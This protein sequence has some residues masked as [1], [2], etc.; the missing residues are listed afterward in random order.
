MTKFKFILAALVFTAFVATWAFAGDLDDALAASQRGD[1]E[2]ALKLLKPLAEQGKVDGQALFLGHIDQ[3]DGQ[4]D[5]NAEFHQLSRQIQ[6]AIEID[7]V[8][9]GDDDVRFRATLEMTEQQI[10]GN[11]LVG[12][13]RS[14]AIRSGEIDQF[15]V[16]VAELG[17][18]GLHFDR[19]AGVVADVLTKPR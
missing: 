9:N 15:E 1:Y 5:G 14:E 2:T 10:D 17:T 13:A 7:G 6:M 18:A 12:A 8:D 3:I 11:H 16:R 4:D 19:H